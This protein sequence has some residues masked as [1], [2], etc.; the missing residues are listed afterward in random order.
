MNVYPFKK[1]EKNRENKNGKKIC[2]DIGKKVEFIYIYYLINK[3]K[4]DEA[5]NLLKDFYQKSP[6]KAV[7]LAKH[8]AKIFPPSMP[9]KC[10]KLLK[11]QSY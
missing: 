11:L 10:M 4:Y 3:K 7:E 2:Q 6:K 5:I 1:T 8:I 9:I